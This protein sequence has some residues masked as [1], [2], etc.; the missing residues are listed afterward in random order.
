MPDTEPVQHRNIRPIVVTMGDPSGIGPEITGKAWRAKE[1]LNIAPFAVISDP[2]IFQDGDRCGDQHIPI[3][4]ISELGE[5]ERVFAHALP[6]IPINCVE[7]PV[8]GK[9]SAANAPSVIRSIELGVE[10]VMSGAASAIVTNPI[11]KAEL[12]KTGFSHPGHTEFLAELARQ[13][14]GR[15]HVPVMMLVAPEL[16]VVPATIHIALRDVARTLTTR[17]I[18]DI[19]RITARSLREEFGIAAPRIALTGLNPHA[20]EN[21]AMGDEEGR[22]ISPAIDAL[23]AEGLEVT[24]PHPADT[25]F[26]AQARKNY[27][28]VIAMYHDQAL[29]PIKTLAFDR[30]VNVTLGLPFCR[31]SPDHGTAFDIAGKNKASATSLIEALNLAEFISSNRAQQSDVSVG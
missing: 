30:G 19:G 25:I 29:I 11:S 16:R 24:G 9:P 8:P 13:T 31:T 10:L 21:G 1:A 14:T 6:I 7:M 27:D 28:A 3:E 20:G 5:V 15:T 18:I 2:R 23:K 12:Y 26:H 22:V 17:H 4:K